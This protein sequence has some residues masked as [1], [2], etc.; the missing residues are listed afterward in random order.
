MFFSRRCKLSALVLVA[1]TCILVAFVQKGIR[2][3]D[4]EKVYEVY[5]KDSSQAYLLTDEDKEFLKLFRKKLLQSDPGKDYRVLL[6]NTLLMDF[7]HDRKIIEARYPQLTER[8]SLVLYILLRV[9]GSI[10]VY[11]IRSYLPV[12]LEDWLFS[13]NGN[14]SDH[15]MR[16]TLVLDAFGIQTARMSIHTKSFPGHVIVD[17]FDPIDKTA[18]LLD[19]N[20][21]GFMYKPNSS[22][23][24]FL[25]LLYMTKE[26]RKKFVNTSNTFLYPPYHFTYVD[27]G[28]GYFEGRDLFPDQINIHR[29]SLP[30]KWKAFMCNELETTFDI[31]KRG[32]P[33]HMP[34]SWDE[35]RLLGY[36]ALDIFQPQCSLDVRPYHAAANLNWD[37]EYQN[38]IRRLQQN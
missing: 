14:C 19:S 17:A 29:S 9:H 32:A 5:S 18:Y 35:L 27:P 2:K 11:T 30:D 12:T 13:R 22:S 4:I 8:Q 26:E 33:V 10:P 38:H 23:G 6:H 37:T 21:N 34:L 31:W 15:A 28:D 16:L 36:S 20:L 25:E 3:N 24:L 7:S 1:V